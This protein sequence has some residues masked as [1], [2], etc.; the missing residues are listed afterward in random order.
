MLIKKSIK[1]K[2]TTIIL[3]MNLM[4]PLML[5][6]KYLSLKIIPDKFFY[7]GN[8]ILLLINDPFISSDKSYNFT[9]FIYRIINLQSMNE[10]IFL[11]F[12]S[13]FFIYICLF[14]FNKMEK[15]NIYGISFLFLELLFIT[16]FMT[17]LGK[18]S[19]QF[20]IYSSCY[21]ILLK[22]KK[23]TN[24]YCSII[25]LTMSILFRSYLGMVLG[26]YL[27][28]LIISET[29]VDRKLRKL[30]ILSIL[31]LIIFMLFSIKILKNDLYFKLVNIRYITNNH[32]IGD[33]DAQ[34]MILDLI[35]N[36]TYSPIIYIINCGINFFR[37]MFPLE[38]LK[39][40]KYFPYIYFQLYLSLV[41][42]RKS[43]I[44]FNKKL[45]LK[46]RRIICFTLTYYFIASIFEP[47]FGSAL[48]H[49][50]P[51][52]SFINY[53]CFVKIK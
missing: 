7:D 37:T 27:S 31:V 4:F 42:L 45:T 30:K 36:P 51:I 23:N 43:M 32:R 11:L 6:F 25:L 28:L 1:I 48:R 40:I 26:V 15:I 20:L 49:Q 22:C 41:L 18:E 33:I 35:K 19:I 13:N 2:R 39:K 24:L 10:W 17:H 38:L 53:I 21:L 3:F 5:L 46:N 47:D 52:I 44:L 12:M 50:M 16:M 34:S 14:P 29:L 8:K 9:A